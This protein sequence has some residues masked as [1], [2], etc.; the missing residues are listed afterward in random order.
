MKKIN[1]KKTKEIPIKKIKIQTNL[2][3]AMIAILG[4]ILII[5]AYS[6]YGAY[7]AHQ[8]PI[9][10]EES[11]PIVEYTH[12]GTFNYIV[13]FKNNTVYNTSI[14]YPG[15]GNIFKKI[16]DYINASLTY[17]FFCDQ[18]ADIDGTYELTA[19]IQTSIWT[20]EYTIIPQ[21]AFSS[22]NS[23]QASFNAN[24]PI[25]YSRFESIVTQINN[26]TGVT[27]GDTALIM[28]CNIDINAET[29]K[30]DISE[31][32]TPS[33]N[34][35][36]GG[37]IIEIEGDLS[38][39][40]SGVLE[41]TQEI[42][43]QVSIEQSL[44]W[45]V[46]SIVFLIVL[47]VFF[48]FTKSDEAA[49]G[50][51]DKRVKKILKKYGE[52]IVETEKLP[53]IEGAKIAPMKSLDDLVKISEELGKPIIH[54]ASDKDKKHTFYVFDEAMS[55]QYILPKGEQLKKTTRCPKCGTKITCNGSLG[56]KTSIACPSC[57]NK[58][59]VTFEETRK[60]F[61]SFKK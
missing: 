40:S 24:F 54:V 35:S 12:T 47:A 8:Q 55:Y 1:I 58:G 7:A 57:G 3:M 50:K 36:L 21:T 43:Q 15:Q 60:P 11:I 18:L 23:K 46:T 28:K 53:T 56:Q 31:S 41:E 49:F 45:S 5:S 9:T 10:T 2:R 44:Y 39:Y 32:F 6:T 52:W 30:G 13:Y 37:N 4:V 25:N 22:T 27:A 48:M 38:Q 51:T 26:E 14:L 34:I 59:T 42:V 29:N 20:K 61:L 33:L 17:R 16:T 19:E